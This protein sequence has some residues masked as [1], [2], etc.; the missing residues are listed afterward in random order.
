MGWTP[1]SE[2]AGITPT[3]IVKESAGGLNKKEVNCLTSR[4]EIFARSA[5]KRK[6]EVKEQVDPYSSTSMVL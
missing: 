5:E 1:C 4:V 3:F 2:G 6:K